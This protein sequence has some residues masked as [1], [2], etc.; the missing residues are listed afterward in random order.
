MNLMSIYQ[1]SYDNLK[2]FIGKCVISFN[3]Y[4]SRI[5][6]VVGSTLCAMVACYA[7]RRKDG[8]LKD[9]PGPPQNLIF[10]NFLE[11]RK[12]HKHL[13]FEEIA[14]KYGKIFKVRLLTFDMVIVSS[15]EAIQEI[16]IEKSTDYAGRPQNA[17]LQV[18]ISIISLMLI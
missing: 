10:G 11:L 5:S 9:I 4:N 8:N 16:L 13:V 17:R 12:K 7:L 1:F 18:N 3:E 14:K 6:I 15:L 2:Q